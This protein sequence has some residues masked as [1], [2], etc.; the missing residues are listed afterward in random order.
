MEANSVD[1]RLGYLLQVALVPALIFMGCSLMT[2]TEASSS[3]QCQFDFDKILERDI[4]LSDCIIHER[5]ISQSPDSTGPLFVMVNGVPVT[6]LI[7]LDLACELVKRLD[8]RVILAD[9]PGTGRSYLKDGCYSWSR[10]R[11]CLGDYLSRQD[12]HILV[13]HDISGPIALPLV[14]ELSVIDRL[15][16]MDTIIKPS[17]FSPPFPMNW[18]RSYFFI[19]KP[20]AY[21]MPFFIYEYKF[22]DMGISRN[23]KVPSEQ[24]ESI[25]GE[26]CYNY[27]KGRLVEVM[28][29]FELNPGTD[30]AI[31]R[32]L[33]RDIPQ[34]FIWGGMDPALGLERYKLPPLTRNQQMVLI[35]QAKHFLMLDFH[36]EVANAIVDWYNNQNAS[37]G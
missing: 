29:G 10:Q 18:L 5:T 37:K 31:R 17:E 15:V 3:G 1:L 11:E 30:R 19:S 28:N 35:P 26:L 27:G 12:H 36:D 6:S 4:E 20:V 25:Y 14:S 8:A 2:T 22:R 23:D 33:A 21:L 24:I 34:L 16:V 9:L 7:Y 13:V 32:G